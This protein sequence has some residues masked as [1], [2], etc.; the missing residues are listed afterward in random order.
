[1]AKVSVVMPCLNMVKYIEKSVR[2]VMNQILCDI[3][4]IVI[5]AGSSDGS[6]EILNNLAKTDERIIILHSEMKS[7]GHQVNM[8]IEYANGEYIGIV[9]TD[10]YITDD[11]YDFLYNKA[12]ETGADYV[13]GTALGFWNIN[14]T[15]QYTFPI[16]SFKNYDDDIIINP[17]NSSFLL[18]GDNF[19]WYG[20]YKAEFLKKICLHESAGA[21]F[22]DFGALLQIQTTAEKAVY[23]EHLIYYYRQDNI[24]ASSYNHKSIFFIANEYGWAEKHIISLSNEWKSSFYRKQFLHLIDRVY[25]MAASKEYWQ[26]CEKDIN[27]IAERL[28]KAF[29]VNILSEKDFSEEELENYQLLI[30]SPYKLYSKYEKRYINNLNRLKQLIQN[31]KISDRKNIVIFGAGIVGRFIAAELIYRKVCSPICF[32]DN[33]KNIQNT[34]W[35]EI[36]VYSPEYCT[37]KYKDTVYIIANLKYADVMKEQLIKLNIPAENI[38]CCSIN[39]DIHLFSEKL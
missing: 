7:Y 34:Q 19:L 9:D 25:T 22:Q 24:N 38:M 33:N 15:L 16:C 28:K 39:A 32:C 36:P 13:K 12:M 26:G 29:E 18:V 10:D 3:E 17:S 31:I 11:A 20:L 30:E 21:A 14:D 37:E 2:S 23:T 1:M 6:L 35:N 5:D 4:I 8:G 27:V